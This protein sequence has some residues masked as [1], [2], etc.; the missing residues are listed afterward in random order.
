MTEHTDFVTLAQAVLDGTTARQRLA[1]TQEAVVVER[2]A[3]GAGATSW[4]LLR[5]S[6]D[7][8]ALA[9]RIRPG[10]RVSLYFDNRFMIGDFGDDARKAAVGIIERDGEAVLG[11]LRPSGIEADTDFPS[12][13]DEADDFARDHP[14]STIIVGAFPA[15]DDDGV[16][17][18]TVD[19]PDAD[20]VVR[21]HPH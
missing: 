12:S 9:A 19:L 2:I 13:A 6:D 20:G 1:E 3:R 11:A 4:Y 14:N 21:P 15:P 16:N 8:D 5:C 18:V 17:A 10:S 7:L